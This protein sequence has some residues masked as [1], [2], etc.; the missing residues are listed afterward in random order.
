MSAK[1]FK[2][3]STNIIIH[4][5]QKNLRRFGTWLS[6]QPGYMGNYFLPIR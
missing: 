1:L 5:K 4:Y 2:I 3:L 6:M